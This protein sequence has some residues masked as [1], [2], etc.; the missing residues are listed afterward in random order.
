MENQDS[1]RATSCADFPERYFREQRGTGETSSADVTGGDMAA[2]AGGGA[3]D[4]PGDGASAGEPGG[5]KFEEELLE[6]VRSLPEKIGSER[7]YLEIKPASL[8]ALALVRVKGKKAVLSF[9]FYSNGSIWMRQEGGE[10]Y[11]M[12]RI[13]WEALE[14]ESFYKSM[15]AEDKERLTGDSAGERPAAAWQKICP[16]GP[17]LQHCDRARFWKILPETLLL[18]LNRN[19]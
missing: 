8:K 11:I 4:E 10:P 12:S 6:R 19:L 18:F 15:S 9:A 5:A 17:A 3:G 2:N 1:E 7:C 13:L 14:R 16:A